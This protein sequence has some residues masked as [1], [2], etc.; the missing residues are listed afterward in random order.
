MSK[1]NEA[2]EG[3]TELLE[4]FNHWTGLLETR[5]VQLAYGLIA[6]N[7]VIHENHGILNSDWAIVSVAL[8]VSFLVVQLVLTQEMSK[9]YAERIEYARDQKVAWEQE[10][11]GRGTSEWPYTPEIEKLG[12]TIRKLRVWLPLLAGLAFVFGVFQAY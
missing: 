11:Q 7:W 3:T 5:S 1:F 4:G 12:K 2:A 8:A 9:Q 6:A 10:F